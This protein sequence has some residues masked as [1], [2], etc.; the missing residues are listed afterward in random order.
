MRPLVRGAQ[1]ISQKVAD[2]FVSILRRIVSL[3][4]AMSL[5]VGHIVKYLIPVLIAV[6]FFEVVSRYVFNKPTIWALETSMMIFGTI[7]ALCWGYTLKIG[8][9]VRVDI[10]YT[11]LSK[12]WKALI[13]VVLTLLFLFPFQLILIRTGIKWSLF[14]IKFKEKMVESSWLPPTAPFRIVLTIGFILFFIQAVSEFI[15]NF[16]YLTRNKDLIQVEAQ[17]FTKEG[18]L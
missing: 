3:I 1:S 6:L 10:F 14:A 7:G 11:M 9:H 8:G 17:V 12:R 2:M 16:Y 15:K 5:K 4:D 18:M 13:D